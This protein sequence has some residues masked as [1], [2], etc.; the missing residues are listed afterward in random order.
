M[1]IITRENDGHSDDMI[2]LRDLSEAFVRETY[3]PIGGRVLQ[4][5]VRAE[6]VLLQT[7]LGRDFLKR[8][9]GQTKII[10]EITQCVF[11][12]FLDADRNSELFL[13]RENDRIVSLARLQKIQNPGGIL[14]GREQAFEF[15]RAYTRPE[16][17]GNGHYRRL[18]NEARDR[19]QKSLG[20]SPLVMSTS[21]EALKSIERNA[22]SQEITFDEYMR[23]KGI[24]KEFIQK[25]AP[26]R[27]E[28][29]YVGFIF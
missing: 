20:K 21:S 23:I 8:F 24:Q 1:K 29:G 17:R 12:E 22:G 6:K 2:E 9:S 4:F 19:A 18:R 11:E 3:T 10:E 26:H 27:T 15:G 25:V 14:Q 16:S 7:S 13:A 28:E 5:R